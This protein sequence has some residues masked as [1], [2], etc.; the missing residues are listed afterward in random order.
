MAEAPK[1]YST[2]INAQKVK[3]QRQLA[4][5]RA[6]EEIIAGLEALNAQNVTAAEQ[7][8]SPKPAR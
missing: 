5:V 4:A 6:T 7:A 8:R 3:L 1:N 2:A